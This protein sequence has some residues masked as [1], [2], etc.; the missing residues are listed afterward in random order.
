MELGGGGSSWIEVGARFSNTYL[1]FGNV[2]SVMGRLNPFQSNVTFH[3]A[4][5]ICSEAVVRRCSSK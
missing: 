3:I 5:F 4:T 1:Q 2:N